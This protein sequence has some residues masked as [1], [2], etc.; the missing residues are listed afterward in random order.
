VE[1]LLAQALS[2]LPEQKQAQKQPAEPG[3]EQPSPV[4][5]AGE[6]PSVFLIPPAPPAPSA[7]SFGTAKHCE[8]LQMAL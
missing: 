4:P 3:F 6:D 1:Q 2:S 7:P 8:L 5:Q